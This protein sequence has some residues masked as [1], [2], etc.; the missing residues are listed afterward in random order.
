MAPQPPPRG[1][2]RP[3]PDAATCVIPSAGSFRARASTI[4]LALKQLTDGPRRTARSTPSSSSSSSKSCRPPLL[5]DE[6]GKL[7]GSLSRLRKLLGSNPIRSAWPKSTLS[8][9]SEAH[10]RCLPRRSDESCAHHFERGSKSATYSTL[11]AG[12]LD[13]FSGTTLVTAPGCHSCLV[14]ENTVQL[15]S[16][17]NFGWR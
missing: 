10:A 2:P 9:L 4:S 16:T 15:S 17:T 1:P 12:I 7:L 5:T 6:F 13:D 3:Q 11:R 14:F 8:G